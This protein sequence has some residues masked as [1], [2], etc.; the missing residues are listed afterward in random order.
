MEG[1]ELSD[2]EV[3]KKEKTL[4]K[5]KKQKEKGFFRYVFLG[6]FLITLVAM[7]GLFF[8]GT[9]DGFQYRFVFSLF[10]FTIFFTGQWFLFD[11][12]ID[13]VSKEIAKRKIVRDG[14]LFWKYILLI[15][16]PII[17]VPI[18]AMIAGLFS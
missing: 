1:R 13:L 9:R 14:G 8:G 16:A 5:L 17:F 3:L 2:K 7:I 15:I 12:R 10:F 18:L 4:Q 6:S 11:R